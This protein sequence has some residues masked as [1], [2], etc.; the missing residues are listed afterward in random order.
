[1]NKGEYDT[2]Y[3]TNK[4]MY[5]IVDIIILAVLF[6]C[7]FAGYKK[8]LAKCLIN[9]LAFIIAVIVAAML[10]KPASLIVRNN[11]EIDENIKS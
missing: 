2:R 3:H 7:V 6:L 10:F 4:K 5:I 1:M 11:T 8:G 9:V